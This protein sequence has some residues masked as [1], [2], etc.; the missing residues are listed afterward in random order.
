MTAHLRNDIV[1]LSNYLGNNVLVRFVNINVYGN[2]LYLDNI[3]IDLTVSVNS[4]DEMGNV[5][6]YPNPSSG[7]FNFELTG[8]TAKQVQYVV[9]DA[10]GRV[11][12]RERLNTGSTYRGLLD[13]R[14]APQG[15]YFLRLES[16][17][18]NRTIKITK[19]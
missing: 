14:E 15:I 9:T 2:N 19:I 7:L 4:I 8:N 16:E 5:N 11:I 10:S 13:L 3:N 17:S 12:K 18:G 1:D 6:V